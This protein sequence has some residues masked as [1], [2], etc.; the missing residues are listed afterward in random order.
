MYK[1]CQKGKHDNLKVEE[2]QWSSVYNT[3]MSFICCY[4]MHT[5]FLL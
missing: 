2:Q 4:A 1:L 3:V 5:C